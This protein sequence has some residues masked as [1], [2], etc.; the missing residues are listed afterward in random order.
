M[1]SIMESG[2]VT[3]H[4]TGTTNIVATSIDGAKTASCTI[5]VTDYTLSDEPLDLSLAV[6]YQPETGDAYKGYIPYEDL[7]YVNSSDYEIIGLTI[8]GDSENMIMALEDASTEPMTHNASDLYNMPSRTQGI[9]ISARLNEIDQALLQI[10]GESLK[11]RGW[12]GHWTKDVNSSG[13][14]YF[15][16]GSGGNLGNDTSGGFTMFVRFFPLIMLL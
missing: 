3:A 4:S 11:S 16:G 8:L 6:W 7:D 2:V 10:G 15:I 1:A 12:T 13:Y 14:F 9:I 5:T